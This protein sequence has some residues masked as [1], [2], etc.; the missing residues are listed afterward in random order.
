MGIKKKK[1]KPTASKSTIYSTII[2]KFLEYP[3]TEKIGS[4]TS[5][6]WK[7]GRSKSY[8]YSVNANSIFSSDWTSRLNKAQITWF[9][10]YNQFPELVFS[11]ILIIIPTKKILSI[12]HWHSLNII[13]PTVEGQTIQE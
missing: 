10:H 8:D 12:Y 4:A 1:K 5:F 9:R 11:C 6:T 7:V 3:T 13:K 2:L